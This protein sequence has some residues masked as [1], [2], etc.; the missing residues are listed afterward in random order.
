MFV[1]RLFQCIEGNTNYLTSI[2][3]Q[4]TIVYFHHKYSIFFLYLPKTRSS[5]IANYLKPQ[6][7]IYISQMHY[8]IYDTFTFTFT[9]TYYTSKGVQ[10]I[11]TLCIVYIFPFQTVFFQIDLL[12]IEDFFQGKG[13]NILSG[14]SRTTLCNLFTRPPAGEHL[15]GTELLFCLMSTVSKLSSCRMFCLSVV[16]RKMRNFKIKDFWRLSMVKLPLFLSGAG[17]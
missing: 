5:V 13:V 1:S 3:L 15:P 10:L 4:Q 16:N 11:Q 14:Q 2:H 6:N 8:Y 7:C 9:Y 17:T 12:N